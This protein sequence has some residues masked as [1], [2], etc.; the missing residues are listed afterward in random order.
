MAVSA[1]SLFYDL[2]IRGKRKHVDSPLILQTT[3]IPFLLFIFPEKEISNGILAAL[4]THEYWLPG[5]NRRLS[6]D[7]VTS[8]EK[9]RE[10]V[11]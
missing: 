1:L 6:C 3:E 9:E 11:C 8:G 2:P 4:T 7:T 10:S 5:L